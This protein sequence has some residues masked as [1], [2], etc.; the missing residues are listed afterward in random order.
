MLFIGRR[1]HVRLGIFGGYGSSVETWPLFLA[2]VLISSTS[3]RDFATGGTLRPLYPQK[4]LKVAD[5][6]CTVGKSS[7]LSSAYQSLENKWAESVSRFE[8][9]VRTLSK[10]K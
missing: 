8:E 2:Q 9:D 5:I 1:N 10:D 3:G 7:P 6:I 4:D